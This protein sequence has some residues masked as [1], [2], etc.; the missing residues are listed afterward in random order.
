MTLIRSILRA[1]R[2]LEQQQHLINAQQR[3]IE[4][5]NQRL[6]RLHLEHLR[7]MRGLVAGWLIHHEQPEID[8]RE[9]L[10]A[11]DRCLDNQAA[12]LEEHVV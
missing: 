12:W 3:L 10:V 7:E 4:D 2:L 9:D 1:F 5:Q 11:L 6:Q 8:L